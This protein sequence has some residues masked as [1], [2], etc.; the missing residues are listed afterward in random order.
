M[1][2]I[3]TPVFTRE[4]M[5]LLPDDEYRELQAALAKIPEAGDIIA[6]SGGLK[7]I[8]WSVPGQ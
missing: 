2:L 1:I 6:G 4:I 3:E 5:R 7:K 8:R